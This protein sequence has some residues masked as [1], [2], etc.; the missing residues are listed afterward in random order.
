[1]TR[2]NETY[3]ELFG[4]STPGWTQPQKY[5]SIN[6]SGSDTPPD[7]LRKHQFIENPYTANIIYRTYRQVVYLDS[8]RPTYISSGTF[9]SSPVFDSVATPPFSDVTPKLLENWRQSK[10][11]LGVS[12]GEGAESVEMITSRLRDLVKAVSAIR[13]RNLGDALRSLSHVPKSHRRSAQLSL[14]ANALTDAWLELQYG[15]LPLIKDISNAAEAVKLVPKVNRVRARSVNKG[16]AHPYGLPTVPQDRLKL[17]NNDRRLQL[18]V[19][20]SQQ[21]SLLERLGLT[22]AMS[23]GWELAPFSFVADWFAPIGD[24]LAT[25]HAVNVM[26]VTK[27][28]QTYS[29]KQIANVDCPTGAIFYGQPVISG[30]TTSFIEV[31]MT[32]TI[33]PSL[34]TAWLASAQTPSQIVNDYDISLKRMVN[35][36][37]LISSALRGLIRRQSF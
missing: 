35:A 14:S 11:S 5:V 22:D 10:F 24:Y 15:W 26:P 17:F 25:L 8:G 29:S 2:K 16:G 13:R 31:G 18:V 9:G 33:H 12:I 19:V 34:P 21:P 28:I 1:M 20:V 7:L 32:R 36:S 3:T 37:A 23:I 30:G 6:K 4:K 27:C